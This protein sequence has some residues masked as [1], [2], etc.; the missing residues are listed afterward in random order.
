[1]YSKAGILTEQLQA[2][3]ARCRRLEKVAAEHAQLQ[4]AQEPLRAELQQWRAL[5][6]DLGQP[7]LPEAVRTPQVV[8]RTV[9]DLR[10]QLLALFDQASQHK[11][12]V[13]RL[14]GKL[15]AELPKLHDTFVKWLAAFTSEQEPCKMQ[16]IH[17]HDFCMEGFQQ[18]S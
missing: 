1:M 4:A 16:A 13:L 18:V 6:A 12:E 14:K 3:E 8:L 9:D 11:A 5:V 2:A 10:G 7:N 15:S 17:E